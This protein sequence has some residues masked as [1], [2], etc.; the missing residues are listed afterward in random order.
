L[1]GT[2]EMPDSVTGSSKA[3]DA[4]RFRRITII[5]TA[6][7][8]NDE[9]AVETSELVAAIIKFG[10][11]VVGDELLEPE[12]KDSECEEDENGELALPIDYEHLKFVELCGDFSEIG[13]SVLRAARLLAAKHTGE[14][15]GA[16]LKTLSDP[17][18]ED[19]RKLIPCLRNPDIMTLNL[20]YER[21]WIISAELVAAIALA[22]PHAVN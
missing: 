16:W 20:R 17:E 21:V 6:N 14:G 11:T 15:D 9:Y 8:V 18:L 1:L 22:A 4:A 2:L 10:W 3:T 7:G 13:C 19:A 12:P 5:D